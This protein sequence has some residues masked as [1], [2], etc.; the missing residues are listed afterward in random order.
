MV[1][2]IIEG[3]KPV[4]LSIKDPEADRLARALAV[5]TGESLTE[6]VTEALRER[7]DNSRLSPMSSTRL[8]CGVR[9]CRITTREHRMRSSAMTSTDCR[10]DGDR[11]LGTDLFVRRASL[12][13]APVPVDRDQVLIARRAFRRYG[14]GYDAAGLNFGDCFAYALA[15][16]TGEPLLFK[17]EDFGRTDMTPADRDQR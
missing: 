16:A 12:E 11:Q 14:K 7:L 15:R 6:A 9:S 8:R 2:E 1:Y 5:A 10:A 3:R 13:P 4:A 17:G